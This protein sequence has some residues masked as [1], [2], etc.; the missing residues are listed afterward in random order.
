[1]LLKT[2]ATTSPFH[3]LAKQQEVQNPAKKLCSFLLC[4]APP[5][6]FDQVLNEL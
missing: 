3:K 4:D 5:G 1:M 2:P 6:P